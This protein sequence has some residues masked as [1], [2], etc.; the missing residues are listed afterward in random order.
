MSSSTRAATLFAILAASVLAS[1]GD[2]AAPTDAGAAAESA[3]FT[4]TGTAGESVRVDLC[5][6]AG[7]TVPAAAVILV[8]WDAATARFAG[9]METRAGMMARADETVPGTLRVAA[10]SEA[11]EAGATG[12]C[13]GSF[14]LELSGAPG[15]SSAIEFDLVET[16]AAS[17]LEPDRRALRSPGR[18]QIL[19]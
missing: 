15:A 7:A 11:G 13:Y 6:P 5:A 17:D 19:R 3:A 9:G 1:C 12:V 10:L 18:I 4:V 14:L 8:R 16:I 2:G